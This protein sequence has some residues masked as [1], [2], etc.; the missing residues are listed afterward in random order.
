MVVGPRCQVQRAVLGADG[1]SHVAEFAVAVGT[2]GLDG[3]LVVACGERLGPHDAR[4]SLALLE[5]DL[6][7][8]NVCLPM[9]TEVSPLG[10]APPVECLPVEQ[11]HPL[12]RLR[13]G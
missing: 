11:V 4:S 13:L 9:A 10:H 7:V 1:E 5:D 2:L 6:A 12:A 3:N 8:L